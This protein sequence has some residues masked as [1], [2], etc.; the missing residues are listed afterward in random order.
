MLELELQAIREHPKTLF[1][2]VDQHE[3]ASM[4]MHSSL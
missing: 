4:H 1:F 2:F 3:D